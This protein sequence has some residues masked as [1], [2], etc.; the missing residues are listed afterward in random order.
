VAPSHTLLQDERL[1]RRRSRLPSRHTVLAG[2]QAGLRRSDQSVGGAQVGGGGQRLAQV[3]R[4]AVPRQREHFAG[5]V[6]G[7]GAANARDQHEVGRGGREEGRRRREEDATGLV[8]F[9][10]ALLGALQY[11]DGHKRGEFFRLE[12]RGE[13]AE[14]HWCVLQATMTVTSAPA[15]T[16]GSS[17][18][19]TRGA[20]RS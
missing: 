6:P 17:S 20:W 18:F 11:D 3:L 16:R 13:S 4:Q 19:G 1:V 9:R 5:Q 10:E 12:R 14:S 7:R 15:R 2:P 8:R